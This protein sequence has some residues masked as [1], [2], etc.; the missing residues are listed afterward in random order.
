S[1]VRFPFFAL[2]RALYAC[3]LVYEV[4]LAVRVTSRSRLCGVA[5]LPAGKRAEE[6]VAANPEK[7]DR[8]F[9]VLCFTLAPFALRDQARMKGARTC[10]S[11]RS[12]RVCAAI[13]SASRRCH[14]DR[15]ISFLLPDR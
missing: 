13:F 3:F 4:P 2:L 11:L 10:K 5:Y 15:N 14:Q 12:G 9:R 1:I 8:Q 7:F 6:A